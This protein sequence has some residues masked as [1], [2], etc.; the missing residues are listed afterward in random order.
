MRRLPEISLSDIMPT[1]PITVTGSHRNLTGFSFDL[2]LAELAQVN[3]EL[4]NNYIIRIDNL[5]YTLI[6]KLY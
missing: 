3:I 5:Q 1:L 4:L 6:N 2:H